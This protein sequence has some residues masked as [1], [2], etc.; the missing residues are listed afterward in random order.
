MSDK[1][2]INVCLNGKQ[3]CVRSDIDKNT[4]FKDLS[5]TIK[6]KYSRRNRIISFKF[7]E[8]T[9]VASSSKKVRERFFG[10]GQD[11]VIMAQE[12]TRDGF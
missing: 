1:I 3:P 12:S 6:E 11:S 7:K 8:I 2:S 5:S 10:V 9:E 4:T